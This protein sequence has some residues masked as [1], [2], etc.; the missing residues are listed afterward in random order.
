MPLQV[1]IMQKRKCTLQKNCLPKWK[2]TALSIPGMDLQWSI[3]TKTCLLTVKNN[4]K[5]QQINTGNILN[6][7]I[8]K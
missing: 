6:R 2:K 4:Q 8:L 7:I 3:K 1:L 5:K